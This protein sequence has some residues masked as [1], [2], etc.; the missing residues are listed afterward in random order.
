M[1]SLADLVYFAPGLGASRTLALFAAKIAKARR[2]RRVAGA[3]R[4]GEGDAALLARLGLPSEASARRTELNRRLSPLAAQFLPDPA[5]A[6]P[7][8][9][10]GTPEATVARAEAVLAG[11]ELLFGAERTVGW[12]PRWGWRWEGTPQAAVFAGDV[13]STWE[14]QRLQGIL[15]LARAARLA[16][17]EDGGRYAHAYVEALLD[18]RRAHPGPDG[19]AWSSALE[20]GLRLVALVQGLALVAASEAFGASDVVLLG[21]VDRHA[22]S[23]AAGLSLDKAVRGNH[24][25]GELAG[26]SCAAGVFPE[27]APAWGADRARALLEDEILRQF[28]P[29]GVNVEQSLPYEKFILE[30][31]EVAG[32]CG[33]AAG[34]PFGEPA[35]NR[36]L[37]AAHHLEAATTPAGD[38]PRVGDCDSGRGADWGEADPFR[39][40]ALLA[41]LRK[42]FGGASGGDAGAAEVPAARLHAFPQGGHAVAATR[43]GHYLFL[44]GGPFGWGIPGPASH[45]HADRLAP[46]LHLAGEPVLIDPGVYG[47]GVGRRLRDAFRVRAAHGGVG[48]RPDPGPVPG[49]T[50]RWRRITGEARLHLEAAENGFE[51]AGEIC[52]KPGNRALIW[53]RS[54]R[55]NQLEQTWLISDRFS[56]TLSGPVTWAFHFAPGVRVEPGTGPGVFTVVAASGTRWRLALDPAGGTALEEGYAAPGY[57]ELVTA[58]VLRRRLAAPSPSRVLIVPAMP[59]NPGADPE[60]EIQ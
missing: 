55:Y 53:Y 32:V 17:G 57:G 28:Y 31:L 12:P 38:L 19:L 20:L 49:G 43:E 25:L 13:R 11:R 58:P 34:S 44:R 41:R 16:P 4:R 8:D 9:E 42:T 3:L 56:Q 10:D 48:L 14:I 59:A 52:W 33:A 40:A 54:I 47:Y 29:D 36:I 5:H 7:G 26:L 15:P 39:T 6:G 51:A 46:V 27:A 37:A 23:L 18:F 2:M 50:F 60:Q 21:M 35:R 1:G 24:L 45:S 22:R 30:F